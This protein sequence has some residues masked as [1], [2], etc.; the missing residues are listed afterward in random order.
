MR[1]TMAMLLI[2]VLAIGCGS[3][4]KPD[5]EPIEEAELLSS[6]PTGSNAKD[7]RAMKSDP[8][9]Q[10]ERASFLAE[11]P[12]ITASEYDGWAYRADD[13]VDDPSLTV[14]AFVAYQKRRD[15]IDGTKSARIDGL[16]QNARRAPATPRPSVDGEAQRKADSL[17]AAEMERQR[18]CTHN[19]FPVKRG[20]R[21]G[22][23]YTNSN[24]K[25][26]YLDPDYDCHDCF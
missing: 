7:R 12:Y 8:E 5:D 1:W 26:V 17:K 19:G 2:A 3:R 24:G 14:A 11:H 25:Q 10:K 22:C 13:S 16:V 20:P 9:Y 21:G 6:T 18:R 15:S 23:Y 4:D